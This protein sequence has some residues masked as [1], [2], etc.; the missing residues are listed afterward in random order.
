MTQY[1][2]FTCI[3]VAALNV[4]QIAFLTILV[5]TYTGEWQESKWINGKAH[6]PYRYK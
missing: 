6:I 5:R 1:I 3:I 4:F 2:P